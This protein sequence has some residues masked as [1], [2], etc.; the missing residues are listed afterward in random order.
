MIIVLST[1]PDRKSAD[2]TA[3]MLVEKRLAACVSIMRIEQSVYRWK[4]KIDEDHECILLA[5]TQDDHV[6]DAVRKI[7]ELHTYDLPDIIVLPIIGGLKEYLTY[8][9]DETQ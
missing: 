1:Y 8:V 4:G 7:R 3:S 6:K 2:A 9:V 5:K